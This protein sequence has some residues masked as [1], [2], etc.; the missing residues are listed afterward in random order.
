MKPVVPVVVFEDYRDKAKFAVV[1]NR[2]LSAHNRK[3]AK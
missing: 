3:A 2:R 1:C